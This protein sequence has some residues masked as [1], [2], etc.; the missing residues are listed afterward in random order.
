MSV[1]QYFET[2]KSIKQN[3]EY[4]GKKLNFIQNVTAEFIGLPGSGR[5][6]SININYDTHKS[7]VV[8]N[9][10]FNHQNIIRKIELDT[11]GFIFDSLYNE[12]DGSFDV[13]RHIL[14]IDD[15]PLGNANV[16][17]EF[18]DKNINIS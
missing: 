18:K 13:I 12:V 1:E 15:N 5:R 4:K 8:K 2:I 17:Y 9:I 6:C 16:D 14:D 7:L 11:N 3:G 10:R